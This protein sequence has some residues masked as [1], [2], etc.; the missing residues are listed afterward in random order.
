VN[1]EAYGLAEFECWS[2]HGYHEEPDNKSFSQP[3]SVKIYDKQWAGP[4]LLNPENW[5]IQMGD[6]DTFV[7]KAI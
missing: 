1:A 2:P 5:H 4:D 7:F 6:S 3:F